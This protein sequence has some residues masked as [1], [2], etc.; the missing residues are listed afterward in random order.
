MIWRAIQ[1]RYSRAGLTVCLLV[2]ASFS[3]AQENREK[4]F[5]QTAAEVYRQFLSNHHWPDTIHSSNAQTLS[6]V[7]TRLVRGSRRYDSLSKIDPAER[8]PEKWAWC[9]VD[10]SASDAWCLPGGKIAV[11]APLLDFTQDDGSLAVIVAHCIAHTKLG[12]ALLRMDRFLKEYLD[13]KSL[14]ES[15]SAKPKETMDFFRMACGNSAYVGI[16]RPFSEKQEIE[17][18]RVGGIIL[19]LAGYRPGEAVVF[20]DRMAYLA[21]KGNS[22]LILSMHLLSNRRRASL[23]PAMEDIA[24]L[25][26]RYENKF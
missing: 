1:Y 23:K 4:T 5:E 25:Y 7:M 14:Q 20:W 12:H 21:N 24:A 19:A 18:D 2:A 17:A 3:W 22:P 9:V 13:K 15:L 6:R 8:R 26:Y 16:V 11:Y 10:D